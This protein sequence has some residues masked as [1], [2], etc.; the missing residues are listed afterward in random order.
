MSKSL[1]PIIK[2]HNGKRVKRE[3]P[4]SPQEIKFDS[5]TPLSQ[6]VWEIHRDTGRECYNDDESVYVYKQNHAN[7]MRL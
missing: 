4:W 1:A 7:L 2:K 6:I 3:N 5:Y